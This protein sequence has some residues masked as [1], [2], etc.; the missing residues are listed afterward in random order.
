M[1]LYVCILYFVLRMFAYDQNDDG[2]KINNPEN[3]DEIVT[4]VELTNLLENVNQDTD[5]N[6][7]LPP[8]QRCAAHTFNLIATTDCR[9]AENDKNYK[10]ISRRVFTKCQALFNKQNQSTIIADKI[11]NILGRYLVT[12]NVT[13]WN[14]FY[15]S[16]IIVVDNIDKMDEVFNELELPLISKP[17]EVAF[18]IEYCKVN[19]MSINL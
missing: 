14:S 10:C 11:K 8:H 17:R 12:P 6:F 2:L 9:D 15:D 4:S 5:F 1:Y 19:K 7:T 3:E 18:L 16:I 13:R